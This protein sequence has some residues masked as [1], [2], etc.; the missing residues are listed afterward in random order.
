MEILFGFCRSIFPSIRDLFMLKMK[1]GNSNSSSPS[2]N[3]LNTLPVVK[4]L[5]KFL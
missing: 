5:L 2:E 4:S 1:E 3:L